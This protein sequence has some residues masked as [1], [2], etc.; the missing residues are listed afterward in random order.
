MT[1]PLEGVRV[2]DLSAVLSGPIATMLLAEQGADVVKV[3]PPGVGDMTRVIGSRRGGTAAL[4]ANCNRSKRSIVV[5]LGDRAGRDLVRELAADA[6]V[7]VQNFRPGVVERLGLGAD[8]LRGDHPELI[9]VSLNAF[10]EQGPYAERPGFDQIVQGMTGAGYVQADPPQL[11]RQAWS[12]KSTSLMA[13]QAITAALFARERGAGGQHVRLSM[14]DGALY[15]LWPDGHANETL[16]GDDAEVHPPIGRAITP[17]RTADGYAT[18][19]VGT[20]EQFLRFVAAVGREELL[21]DPRFATRVARDRHNP[22][23]RAEVI[24][25]QPDLTTEEFLD[26]LAAADVPAGPVLSPGEVST[27][28]QVVAASSLVETDHPTMGR[29]RQPRPPARFEATPATIRRSAPLLGE[30][31]DEVLAEL[32]RTP[33]AIAALRAEGT[34]A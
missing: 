2:V 15:F 16:V 18:L 23:W 4:F 6:D 12:D 24:A 31:T 30:H 11:M 34:V 27:Y 20:D 32:G 19:A 22:E 17:V 14:I 8:D 7:F 29:L 10:G 28:P 26:R 1:G 25:A 5:D 33:D 3:E 21:E 9:Y 13:A